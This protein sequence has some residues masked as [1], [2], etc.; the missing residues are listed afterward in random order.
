M[1]NVDDTEAPVHLTVILDRFGEQNAFGGCL[2][3]IIV[4]RE[5]DPFVKIGV[6]SDQFS[7]SVNVF[8][9]S[10]PAIQPA[11]SYNRGSHCSTY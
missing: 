6:P 8:R 9:L 7:I 5:G 1:V 4:L 3:H 10:E 11:M 2:G